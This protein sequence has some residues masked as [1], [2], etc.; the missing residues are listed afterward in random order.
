MATSVAAPTTAAIAPGATRSLTV[1]FATKTTGEPGQ[2]M[3]VS[4]NCTNLMSRQQTG[5]QLPFKPTD[6]TSFRIL[7]PLISFECSNK[8]INLLV[9]RTAKER[10]LTSTRLW[11]S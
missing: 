8:F 4:H 9:I 3:L 1:I 6:T 10:S 11:K 2:Q 5:V 7:Q